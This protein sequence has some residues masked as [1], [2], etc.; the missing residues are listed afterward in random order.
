MPSIEQGQSAH[1]LPSAELNAGGTS[2]SEVQFTTASDDGQ[3]AAGQPLVCYIPGSNVMRYRPFKVR[4]GGRAVGGSAATNF[5][6]NL[7]FGVSATIA[8]NTTVA[9]TGAIALAANT[10][11]WFL[12]VDMHWSGTQLT[13]LQKGWVHNTA[14]AQAIVTATAATTTLNAQSTSNGFTV[15]GQFSAGQAANVAYVDWFEVLTL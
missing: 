11:G 13:G 12:E 9:T 8:S 1:L 7:D 3:V 5:T 2:T 15:T 10:T 14:V 6:A 4:V